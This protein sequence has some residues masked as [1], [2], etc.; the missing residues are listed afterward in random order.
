MAKVIN[1]GLRVVNSCE[2]FRIKYVFFEKSGDP[3]KH[4]K[5]PKRLQN[6]VLGDLP[7]TPSRT[8]TWSMDG[9]GWG[10][11]AYVTGSGPDRPARFLKAFRTFF[12]IFCVAAKFA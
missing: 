5:H 3:P 1:S 6:N 4:E 2:H 8:Q 11:F 7:P 9:V 10:V 12:E